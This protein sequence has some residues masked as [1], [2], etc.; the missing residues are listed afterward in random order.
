[1]ANIPGINQ[2]VQPN[3]FSRVRTLTRATSTPGGP[4]TLSV[5]GTG[6]REEIIIDSANGNG[7]DG[8]NPDFVTQSDSYGRYFKLSNFPV[9]SNRTELFLNGSQLKVLEEPI[10]TSTFS[11]TFDARLDIETG[12]IELQSASLVD[13]G[14]GNY[15]TAAT[16]N[17]GGG[18]ITGLTLVDENAPLETW[19]VRCTSV[20]RDSYGAPE[21]G[22]ASFVAFGSVS[23]QLKDAYGQPYIWQSNGTTLNNTV[24]SFAI[25]NLVPGATFDVGDRFII[26]IQSRVLKRADQLSAKYI[27]ELDLNNPTTY[28]DPNI[29]FN[30]HGEPSLDNALSLGSLM[31]FENGAPSVLAI[32]AKPPLP[33][34]TS[35]VLLAAYDAVSK[36]GGSDG[37]DAYGNFVFSITSPGKPDAETSL[38]FF[39]ENEDGSSMQVF[40]NKLSFYDPDL[41]SSLSAYL[42]NPTSPIL[43][44][45][46]INLNTYSY[47]VLS[48]EQIE[49]EGLDGAISPIGSGQ[50]ANFYS[51]TISLDGYS[52]GKQ[53]SLPTALPENIGRFA[54]LSV[55]DANNCVI[56]RV[57]GTFLSE[58]SVQWQ[59]L[60]ET[61]KESE[62]T[63]YVV[64]TKDLK[65]PKYKGLRITYIDQKDADFYDAGWSEVLEKLE[66]QTAN[67]LVP[68]PAQ[69]F[70]SIIQSF[71]VHAERMSST[72]YK[73]ERVVFTGALQ[74]LT[75]DNV[76]GV[77][78]A[79]V[80]DLGVLEGIQG[81]DPEEIL[82]GN[83]E[84]LADYSVKT[85]FGDTFRVMYFYPDEIIKVVSSEMTTLPGYFMAAAAGGWFAGQT[86]VAQPIT[87]KTLVGFTISNS[88]VFKQTILDRLGADGI[89]VVQP[90]A[91]AAR[92]LHGKTTVQS[93]YPE[94]EEMSIVFIRD[95][96]AASM[97]AGFVSF[98]GQPED[99]TLLPSLTA[100]A[101]ALLRSYISAGIITDFK[102]LTVG[103]DETEPR[104]WNITV[105]VQPTYPVN[106]IWI[107]VGIGLL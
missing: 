49:S 38:H 24:L 53:L 42:Q 77:S 58:A 33:R 35:D 5:V 12:K 39:I 8:F 43:W 75:T 14:G 86:N 88:K 98:I 31:A 32:Q 66:T 65:L 44:N 57:S 64:I 2:Y 18:T 84:D 45:N 73:R 71:R 106:W 13:Q 76:L 101:L 19:T 93:G 22:Y 28:T 47:T 16:T 59:L 81:D 69:T 46:F 15:F 104:Q 40:P 90:I 103:R 41:T 37:T 30:N 50:T 91:G 102:N 60:P 96:I 55:S 97:R 80:E 29:L 21:R 4:R 63:Q 25:T 85:N 10:T 17:I 89:C 11:A 34:R 20:L 99:K 51:P 26:K 54:I 83:V 92:V 78:L 61:A 67:I 105:Q 52:V 6:K 107:D 62:A 7:A 82:E 56:T 23:G 68:L 94:E 1:M 95:Y 79:A 36:T 74:G 70:S 9:I 48:G 87:N 72:Y 100:K 27:A 3:T